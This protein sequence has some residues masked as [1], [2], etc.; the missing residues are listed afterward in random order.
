MDRATR[1][2]DAFRSAIATDGRHSP[3]TAEHYARDLYG[4]LADWARLTANHGPDASAPSAPSRPASPTTDEQR[5]AAL[6]WAQLDAATLRQ[7]LADRARRR[8]AASSLRRLLASLRAFYRWRRRVGL[9]GLDPS[10]GLRG[11]KVAQRLPDSLT[12]EDV[13]RLLEPRRAVASAASRQRAATPDDARGTTDPTLQHHDLC[14]AFLEARDRALI[15][16]FY[17][18]GLRLS[19]LAALDESDGDAIEREGFVRVLGKGGKVRVVPVGRAA[20]HAIRA[21]RDAAARWW[22]AAGRR[23]DDRPLFRA[24]NGARLARRSIQQRLERRA[25]QTGLERGLHPHQLRHACATHLLESSGDLRG[26]QELLG[27]ADLATTEIYTHLDFQYLACVIDRAHPRA[28]R[29]AGASESRSR[30]ALPGA[31]GT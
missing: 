4:L 19:E 15:E 16:L 28:R 25:A 12:I 5:A 3:R 7:L 26:V 17:S 10:V 22:A 9:P 30:G 11:P 18:S 21:M 27:H 13:A 23:P 14:A 31:D 20:R 8:R 29:R 1:E 6:D 2:V 24:R